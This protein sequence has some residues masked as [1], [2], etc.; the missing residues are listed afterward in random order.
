M[1][2]R[3]DLAGAPSFDELV[4]RVRETV[5][6]A[7]AHEQAPFEQIVARLDRQPD[8]ARH[9]VFQ[10]F[11]AHVPLA[12]LP[13]PGAEPYDAR[14]ATSRFDLTLFVEEEPGDALELAWE[15]S[16][17]LFDAGTIERF[18]RQYVRLLEA[19]L[20]DPDPPV[21]ALPMLD[22]AELGEAAAG[23]VPAPA[24]RR[25]SARRLPG[26]LHARA[27]RAPRGRDARTRRRSASRAPAL[28]YGELNARA[29]RLAHRLRELGA[30]AE[31]LVALFLEP[32]LEIVVAI[33]GVLK[34]GAAYVPLDPEYPSD[35]LAF[36]L[37]DT[38][39]PLVVTQRG[40]AAIA[41][42]RAR[43]PTSA[44]TAT[45]PCWR[46]CRT[47]ESGAARPRRRTSPT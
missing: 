19:A 28:S 4:A 45:R 16:T 39:A 15:Y 27:L 25:R 38:A 22:D 40:A 5:L 6:W 31:T 29:N 1:A 36:V 37:E 24:S 9:P 17:D 26:R 20:A 13:L 7:I 2:L 46:R 35:R 43:R 11:C 30:G 10:V 14:P 18:A 33:L 42:R 32:S 8:L 47:R 41:C 21:G 44:W 12:P 3:G 34:A 23:P